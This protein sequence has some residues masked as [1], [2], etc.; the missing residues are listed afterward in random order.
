MPLEW[1]R[2]E[3]WGRGDTGTHK[4]SLPSPGWHCKALGFW[5]NQ[6]QP[7]WQRRWKENVVRWATNPVVWVA[8]G[9]THFTT[10][11]FWEETSMTSARKKKGKEADKNIKGH[12]RNEFPA[13]CFRI[14]A[15]GLPT[16]LWKCLTQGS[17]YWPVGIFPQSPRC[18]DHTSLGSAD[19]SLCVL[20]V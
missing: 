15:G 18:W 17:P 2:D 9:G 12:W 16:D 11:D 5:Q 14:S 20:W 6:I 13:V 7:L 8:A 4:V 1:N 3:F 10:L 19:S